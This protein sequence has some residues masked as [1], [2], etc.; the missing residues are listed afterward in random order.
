MAIRRKN[1]RSTRKLFNLVSCPLDLLADPEHVNFSAVEALLIQG[2][3]PRARDEFHGHTPLLL[4][5]FSGHPKAVRALI[6]HSD[7]RARDPEGHSALTLAI[8]LARLE[9]V[10]H[11]CLADPWLA[12]ASVGAGGPQD[13]PLCLALF[14][15]HEDSKEIL[16]TILS[17]AL[18]QPD[19]LHQARYAA[20]IANQYNLTRRANT[21]LAHAKAFEEQQL[22]LASCAH[23]PRANNPSSSL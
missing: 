16:H 22:L 12:T 6:P 9:C 2:A 4:A 23:A 15:Q 7:L 5:A 19:G 18:T 1:K 3:D 14:H 8:N 11:L 21:I 10:R 20:H 13:T 17:F